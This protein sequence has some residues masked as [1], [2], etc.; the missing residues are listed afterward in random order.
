MSEKIV[1]WVS[2][3]E[4]SGNRM[5]RRCFC[6]AGC[7]GDPDR[8]E[9]FGDGPDDLDFA[10][11]PNRLVFARSVPNGDHVVDPYPIA[12][13]ML[14]CGY[15]IVPVI[16]YR[17]TEFAIEGQVRNYEGRTPEAALQYIRI[18]VEMMHQFAA[19]LRT[20]L[21]VVPYEPF[22]LWPAMRKALF[23][24]LGLPPPTIEFYNANEAYD[25]SGESILP[26]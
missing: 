14:I 15:R 13:R 17:K 25:L 24:S 6:S 23:A 18:C 20:P 16:V 7:Y 22:I 1:Y 5:M 19:Y 8:K 12:V 2:A 21:V 10:E 26:F 11:L 3:P 9:W 4:N